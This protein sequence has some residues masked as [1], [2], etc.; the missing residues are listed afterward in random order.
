MSMKKVLIVDDEVIVRVMLR[1]IV[2][3]EDYGMEIAADVSDGAQALEYCENYV[4]DFL[5]TDMKM[6]RM[7]GIEL[8]KRLKE[9]NLL[10]L[11]LVISGYTEF[12]LVR[13]ALRLGAMDYILKHEINSQQMAHILQEIA[14]KEERKTNK[15]LSDKPEIKDS[16]FEYPTEGIYG[17]AL[18][19]ISDFY[20]QTVRFR[21]NYKEFLEKPMGELAF[22]IPR[23]RK[24]GR[25][26]PL[27]NG[28]YFFLYQGH[29]KKEEYHQEM[30][31]AVR[32]LQSMYKNYMNL[33]ISCVVEE[34][35]LAECFM[36]KRIRCDR[37]MPLTI[38][39][40]RNA[41]V[42]AWDHGIFL[43]NIEEIAK[44]NDS[45]LTALYEADEFMYETE[46]KKFFQRIEMMELK[47]AVVWALQLLMLLGQK[48][49][50]SG[51]EADY[52]NLFL[53]DK[54]CWD[55]LWEFQTIRELELWMTRFFRKEM[56]YARQCLSDRQD[57][58]IQRAKRFIADNCTDPEL[59][60]VSVADYI[61]LN[62]TYFSTCFVRETEES[63][64]DYLR[65]QRM[66]RAKQ[67]L[68][69][70]NLKIYEVS[71]RVGYNNVEHF[72]RTFKK[73]FQVSPGE[74]RAGVK[75]VGEEGEGR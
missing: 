8:M 41:V 72:N 55:I 4:V 11:T 43:N 21:E 63:F 53:A 64:S 38:L 33:D 26:I 74:Y 2:R 42:T 40:G 36:E 73:C 34:E 20:Q 31:T 35:A 3:W 59:T 10:P 37:M 66:G 44:R 54:P 48:F 52:R 51:L 57:T 14:Q 56:E 19:E 62:P 47:S 25:F 6:P 39:L 5:I 23:F 50:E 65:E 15:E 46:K 71:D 68:A 17:A 24:R 12:D 13:D 67:L 30:L 7:D 1:S 60:L 69:K 16:F 27:G 32:Q 28:R 49:R 58:I 75:Q 45:L 70:T 9:K 22:Q 61:G 29:G 18:L